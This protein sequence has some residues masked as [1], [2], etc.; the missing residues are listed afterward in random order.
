MSELLQ[1]YDSESQAFYKDHKYK[2]DKL[3]QTGRIKKIN[4]GQYVCL[5]TDGYNKTTY[6]LEKVNGFW[7][8]NCQG[9]K[10]RNVCSHLIALIKVRASEEI[11]G[12]QELF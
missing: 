7:N 2:I 3:V 6:K 9:F 11:K 10:K 8:C 4:E 12:Q 5:P 1:C